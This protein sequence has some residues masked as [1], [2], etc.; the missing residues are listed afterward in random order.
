MDLHHRME[1]VEGD[2]GPLVR[3]SALTPL[4]LERLG[5]EAERLERARHPGVVLLVEVGH[6]HLDLEWA[7]AETLALAR[8]TRGAAAR[9]VARLAGTVAD[10]HDRGI[11][12]GRIDESHVVVGPGGQPRLCGVRGS[13]PGGFEPG[14]AD[15]VADVGRVLQR[16]LGM[17][18]DAEV[19]PERRWRAGP[20]STSRDRALTDLAERATDPDP[21]RRPTARALAHALA[22]LVPDAA[23]AGGTSSARAG[24]STDLTPLEPEVGSIGPEPAHRPA[25]V[26]RLEPPGPSKVAGARLGV[27][28]TSQAIVTARRTRAPRI[29]EPADAA[30]PISIPTDQGPADEAHPRT[31]S[32]GRPTSGRRS[33]LAIVLGLAALLI[34][35]TSHQPGG[36]TEP[37]ASL[38]P[39]VIARP[40]GDASGV[41]TSPSTVVGPMDAPTARVVDETTVEVD[42]RRYE[43]GEPGDLVVVEDWDCDGA[44]SAGVLRPGTGEIFLFDRWPES[45]AATVV[46]RARVRGAVELA[47][48]APGPAC[49]APR[50][51]LDDGSSIPLP[52]GVGR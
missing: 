27:R 31:L 17:G 20:R 26:E 10:L 5:R 13:D 39:A 40:P 42:G 37:G 9:I 52:T 38:A 24:R 49:R 36:G 21:A 46:A 25:D 43:V 23:P 34:A 1:I 51:V 8:L 18:A 32:P 16:A 44:E 12:H 47:G 30:P 41:P 14:P 15:D 48:S 4:G 45:G 7:G 6:D 28:R 33:L 50:V 19:V 35:V 2:G 29:P 22:D 3:K 11:V